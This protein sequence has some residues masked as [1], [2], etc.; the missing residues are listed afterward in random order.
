MP[1]AVRSPAKPLSPL[2]I[3][4]ASCASSSRMVL[5][6]KRRIQFVADAKQGLDRGFGLFQLRDRCAQLG[7]AFA[8][9]LFEFCIQSLT[10]TVQPGLVQIDG[11]MAGEIFGQ[12]EGVLIKTAA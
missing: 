5:H 1:S 8:H 3:R 7:G 10:F 6:L 9:A 2:T 11:D 4:M 12:G